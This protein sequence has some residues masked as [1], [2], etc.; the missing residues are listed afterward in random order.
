MFLRNAGSL[1]RRILMV[2]FLENEIG[3]LNIFRHL[4][5]TSF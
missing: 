4:V 5:H 3:C 1:M 2:T